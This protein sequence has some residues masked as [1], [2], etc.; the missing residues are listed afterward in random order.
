MLHHYVIDISW[1]PCSYTCLVADQSCSLQCCICLLDLAPVICNI[2]SIYDDNV[3]DSL[4]TGS[5]DFRIRLVMDR[6]WNPA[7]YPFLHRWR[8]RKPQK[9]E[10]HIARIKMCIDPIKMS[11]ARIYKIG[12]IN[13]EIFRMVAN[14]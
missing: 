4:V 11:A 12:N 2:R 7:R 1:S 5:R 14:Q 9:V 10:T 8:C 13:K 6:S 3:F